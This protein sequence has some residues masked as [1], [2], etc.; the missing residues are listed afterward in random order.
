MAYI[1]AYTETFPSVFENKAVSV[2]KQT[3][4]NAGFVVPDKTSPF[5]PKRSDLKIMRDDIAVSIIDIK[6]KLQAL[7][8]SESDILNMGL[9]MANGAF[10]DKPEKHLNR[11]PEIFKLFNDEMTEE[12]KKALIYKKTPPLLALETLT[13]S[14]MSFVAQYTGIKGQNTT[15]GNTSISAV[16]AIKQSLIELQKSPQ[17][18]VLCGGANCGDTYSFLSN[19]TI[20][21]HIDGWKESAGVGNIF[22]KANPSPKDTVLAKISQVIINSKLPKL[23]TQEI[24]RDW[25]SIIPKSKADLLIFSGAFTPKEHQLDKAYCESLCPQTFSFFDDYGNMGPA[26]IILGLIKGIK[27]LSD[28]IKTVDVIDRDVYGRESLIRVE[29]C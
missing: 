27:S 29:R 7:N 4:F 13:N 26:N 25:T 24:E 6:S 2:L 19:S 18:M 9:F 16:Y 10:L 28:D 22:F 1:I 21:N 20:L 11:M 17:N 15:F 14:S 23:D 3:S 5:M 12:D 8:L